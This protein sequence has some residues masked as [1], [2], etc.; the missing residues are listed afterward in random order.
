[1]IMV[2]LFCA[3]YRAAI[4]AIIVSILPAVAQSATLNY[5]EMEVTGTIVEQVSSGRQS[6]PQLSG[7]FGAQF[8]WR[9][10]SSGPYYAA[11]PT[12]YGNSTFELDG[13][14]FDT[15]KEYKVEDVIGRP[16]WNYPG[17]DTYSGFRFHPG[18]PTF[19]VSINKGFS[20][21]GSISRALVRL[22]LGYP[23]GGCDLRWRGTYS[24][25]GPLEASKFENPTIAANVLM[26]DPTINGF[27]SGYAVATV[28]SLSLHA[29]LGL[30]APVPLPASAPLLLIAMLGLI[31]IRRRSRVHPS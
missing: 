26:F 21:G 6:D 1:M 15:G 22:N 3:R 10:T 19:E 14:E 18:R 7:L 13:V 20:T 27:T 28:D 23:T 11:Y 31:A 17:T 12:V 9:F 24:T 30:L 8:T 25:Y 4:A 2:S 5:I 16:Y 29:P